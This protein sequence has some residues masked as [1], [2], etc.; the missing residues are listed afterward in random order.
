MTYSC[1]P[2]VIF[3]PRNTEE[4]KNYQKA[5]IQQGML[6]AYAISLPSRALEQVIEK[7]CDSSEV[8]RLSCQVL[9]AG[10]HLTVQETID[11]VEATMGPLP[12]AT[13]LHLVANRLFHKREDSPLRAAYE[14]VKS[15]IQKAKEV[16]SVQF[17]KEYGI[18]Q[19]ET[20]EYFESMSHNLTYLGMW[21]G[22]KVGKALAKTTK[23]TPSFSKISD[24]SELIHEKAFSMQES[25]PFIHSDWET[26]V[27]KT[28]K[29]T[30]PIFNIKTSGRRH[31]G[32]TSF[33]V[34]TQPYIMKEFIT[35]YEFYRELEGMKYLNALKLQNAVVPSPI[36]TGRFNDHVFAML[37]PFV[38]TKESLTFASLVERVKAPGTS[39]ALQK[40]YFQQLLEGVDQAGK[41]LG[42]MHE[43]TKRSFTRYNARSWWDN[44][45]NTLS[46]IEDNLCDL[47]IYS[48]TFDADKVAGS[49]RKR[50][51]LNTASHGDFHTK[52]ALWDPIEKKLAIIDVEM[53]SQNLNPSKKPFGFPQHDYHV[54]L[55][56]IERRGIA[57]WLSTSEIELLKN[58]FSAGYQSVFKSKFDRSIESVFKTAGTLQTIDVLIEEIPKL[59]P[60]WAKVK[61]L[62]QRSKQ[63][64]EHLQRLK[65]TFMQR[66]ESHLFSPAP[67]LFKTAG[68]LAGRA[69]F[70]PMMTR[71]GELHPYSG[72]MDFASKTNFQED[73]A[74]LQT[75]IDSLRVEEQKLREIEEPEEEE[76]FED[77]QEISSEGSFPSLS[78]AMPIDNPLQS[79]VTLGSRLGSKT[80]LGVSVPITAP[81]QTSVTISQV[82]GD[83]A[84]IGLSVSPLHP[85]KPTI[86]ATIG[87]VGVAMD[88]RHPTNAT[89]SLY[90]PI[91]SIPVGVSVPIRNIKN[92]RVS[93]GIPGTQFNIS[94]SVHKVHSYVKKAF[95]WG[96][97][98]HRHRHHHPAP[99]PPPKPPDP[100]L[101]AC[102]QFEKAMELVEISSNKLGE[103]GTLLLKNATL[104]YESLN[105]IHQAAEILNQQQEELEKIVNVLSEGPSFAQLSQQLGEHVAGLA[106]QN[107]ELKRNIPKLTE[108]LRP[109]IS[110][111]VAQRLRE[112]LLLKQ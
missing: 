100:F 18:P 59:D 44:I 14:G 77:E 29:T 80:D 58:Q 84:Q 40:T 55:S 57:N 87:S 16:M 97:K 27:Q 76:W 91:N 13:P 32:A 8:T 96:R 92:I 20:R 88:P 68:S 30:A 22:G 65:P 93:I 56:D 83:M 6:Q 2:D 110:P 19:E 54:F 26:W 89:I 37:L 105:K 50:F 62:I 25:I 102:S 67:L 45:E 75:Y 5:C 61:K 9:G 33:L 73:F 94:T 47:A 71:R 48:H 60:R 106:Q 81:K 12:P 11:S 86:S 52:N 39:P 99:P 82:V 42:E 103:K 28:L 107:E 95:G 15:E 1:D 31:E 17:Q 78:F 66:F 98:K 38:P 112:N 36:A 41:A 111:E 10:I 46:A 24:Y 108:A 109:K 85:G 72:R 21:G 70:I 101:V 35:S 34:G 23:R 69:V 63:E 53:L 74:S 51:G 64:V 43:Q 49:V 79:S 3:I 4:L 104:L 90:V 7:V